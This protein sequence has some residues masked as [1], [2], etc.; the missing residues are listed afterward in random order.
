[1]SHTDLLIMLTAAALRRHPA[2]NATWSESGPKLLET[3]DVAVAVATDAGLVVPVVHRADE[4]ALEG[5]VTR[6]L[7]LVEAAR[8]G[9]LMPDDLAGGSFTISNLGMFGVDSFAAVVNAPQAAILAVGRI[10]DRN[11]AV[12]GAAVV[13]PS[14][15]LT[16]SFRLDHAA[17]LQVLVDDLVDVFA[18]DVGVPNRVRVHAPR[19][20]L[21]RSGRD[22]RPC[23][24]ALC[25]R[26]RA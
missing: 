15:E 24:R 3:I 8:A 10:A 17:V 11:V 7:A 1:M 25:L 23:S 2:V 22:S 18:V 14:T 19:T 21:R 26:P 9:E 12:N 20:G 16:V 4:L 5:I 13:R 6:R